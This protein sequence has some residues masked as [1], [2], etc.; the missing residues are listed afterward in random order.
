MVKYILYKIAEFIVTRLPLPMA[1]GFATF[2]CDLQ[3]L[4]SF[5]D[6]LAV[7]NNLSIILSS[8]KHLQ[9]KTRDVFRNFGKYLVEFFCMNKKFDAEFI[10]NNVKIVNAD[11]LRKVFERGKGGI[12]V[13][14][15]IGNWEFGAIL[16][17]MLGYPLLAVALPHKERPVN[18]LFNDQRESKGI[19]V[20][21]PHLAIRKGMETLKNNQFVALVADRDFTQ[22]GEVLDFFGK[23]ALIPKGAALFSL[24]TGAPIIPCF[25]MRNSDNTF[26]FDIKDPI[27]PPAQIDEDVKE[28]VLLAVM[29]EYTTIIEQKIREFPTQWLMFRQFWIQ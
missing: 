9:T 6:R 5:R 23:R 26:T 20:V 12:I 21:P 11:V 16:L 29:K 18:D 17:G 13:T 15:H 3:Y 24:K 10:K 2:F 28:S 27:I 25:L 8:E 1:Y 4:F 7:Q 19:T 22:S 14:A